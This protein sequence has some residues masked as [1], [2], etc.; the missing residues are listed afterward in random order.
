MMSIQTKTTAAKE[1]TTP[2]LVPKLRFPEFRKADGWE[3]IQLQ[4]IAQPVTDRAVTGDG[5]NILSLSGEHGLV[6][7]SD[8]FGKKIA[9][10]SAERYLKL[11]RN[12]FVYND[13]TTKASNFGTIKRLSKYSGG[14]VS[15]IYKCFRFHPDE[16]PIFWEWYFESGSHEAELGSLVNEGARAGRFNISISQFLSTSAGRPEKPEQ[17]KIAECL[18]SVD[19]LIAAQARKLDALKTH[20]KGLMQQLFPREGETQPRLRFANEGEW[21]VV[22]LPE[23]AFF[24]EGPGIMAVDFRDEGVP[25]VRLAGV[26]GSG[27]TLCG[28]NYLDPEKVSQKWSHFRLAINDLIISTSATF[29]LSSMVTEAA[30]GAVFYTGLIR[31]RPS[32]ERLNLGY[33]KVFLGCPYFARQAESA[34]VGGGIKHFGPSH[35]KQMEIPIPPV[36]EQ[37]RI[38]DSLSSLDEL[39]AAQT[40]KLEALKT[41]KQGLMQQLF[42]SPAEDVEV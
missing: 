28:C 10:D 7:Q 4:K 13:R 16:N 24:Q 2:A 29:G 26:S 11:L 27:V 42:P 8:Y 14:I 1:A 34:A 23:V 32:S 12:D 15:P 30:E 39:I 35:L 25:L 3:S 37:R 36:D 41:H 6:L 19:E 22:G 9:G 40:Q 20:K 33:L 38:A 17:Q 21:V 31:F 18:S 5:D